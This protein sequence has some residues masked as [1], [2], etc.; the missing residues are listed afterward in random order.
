[1]LLTIKG[2]VGKQ[3][4][5]IMEG[6]AKVWWHFGEPRLDSLSWTGPVSSHPYPVPISHQRQLRRA[7][8]KRG[9]VTGN[10]TDATT[11]FRLE[12]TPQMKWQ[13]FLL[14]IPSVDV[15]HPCEH[16]C[17]AIPTESTPLPSVSPPD[18]NQKPALSSPS[19]F[20]YLLIGLIEYGAVSQWK[21]CLRL[22]RDAPSIQLHQLLCAYSSCESTTH[23]LD[24]SKATRTVSGSHGKPSLAVP[25]L[26]TAA[27]GVKRK[28]GNVLH[29]S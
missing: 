19:V 15:L 17:N 7:Y 2:T 26:L 22:R 13:S 1:M 6:W 27:V 3:A 23:T 25:S 12:G 29:N 24:T 18:L 9:K 21:C 8:E 10:L 5:S 4:N 14:S 28:S 11:A 16:T 20:C